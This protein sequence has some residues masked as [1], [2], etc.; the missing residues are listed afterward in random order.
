MAVTLAQK[1]D[2]RGLRRPE[3]LLE[4]A[5]ALIDAA[6]GE[7]LEVLTSDPTSLVDFALWTHSSGD[8]LLESTQFGTQFRFVVRKRSGSR[9][10]DIRPWRSVSR[11][12]GG[13]L[14]G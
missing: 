13:R 2:L 12:G 11:P 8:D 14:L 9:G 6:P 7:L 10:Q 5:Q 4:L 1:L 3:P